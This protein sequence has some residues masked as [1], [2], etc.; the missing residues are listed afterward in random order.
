MMLF[1]RKKSSRRHRHHHY[2]ITSAAVIAIAL[3]LLLEGIQIFHVLPHGN[4]LMSPHDAINIAFADDDHN[5]IDHPTALLLPVV[6]VGVVPSTSA[7]QTTTTTTASA[8]E[9][10]NSIIA[11]APVPGMT[12][13]FTNTKST[14]NN[15]KSKGPPPTPT[16]PVLYI[17][18]VDWAEGISAWRTSVAA[19]MILAKQINATLVA[20]D[21]R[22]GR[23][24][25]PG[26][27]NMAFFELFDRSL[28]EQYH[29]QWATAEEYEYVVNQT[30]SV[31]GGN[32]KIFDWCIASSGYP[33]CSNGR[34]FRK[35][36]LKYSDTLM[37]AIQARDQGESS[38]SSSSS[39]VVV[40]RLFSMWQKSFQDLRLWSGKEPNHH[41]HQRKIVR[42]NE[43]SAI[44]Q[45]NFRFSK[46][47]H[48][49]AEQT[50]TSMN[51][52]SQNQDKFAVIHWRA[53]LQNID[54]ER[55]AESIVQAKE[56]MAILPKDT[57]FVLMSSLALDATT[58]KWSGARTKAAN[59]TAQLAL[60][61]LVYQHDFRMSDN[62]LPKQKDVI[63]YAAVDLL[64]AQRA[65]SFS[66]CTSECHQ[67]KQPLSPYN[68]CAAC[69][70]QGFFARLALGEK[71]RE[72]DRGRA[73]W[74]CW[75]RNASDWPGIQSL[76]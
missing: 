38:S 14:N 4:S 31:G 7:E 44:V 33:K 21:I 52:S 75:P 8:L 32:V 69:N 58:T 72:N 9:G 40:L 73:R 18:G 65:A 17:V 13:V 68:S 45:N 37:N 43:T 51:I 25:A 62:R 22:G 60:S 2:V 36:Q 29:N 57:P 74:P 50:L 59:S 5:N 20:P 49:L 66:T 24:V 11:P 23:L 1:S 34:S 46:R 67:R 47:I 28:L 54:Y 48:D 27:G 16:T 71:G 61:K 63:V 42:H 26:T 35:K 10:T 19:V 76:W 3:I 15:N 6:G 64:L 30:K 70:H 55:C 53:E 39:D 56:A 12:T 41:H